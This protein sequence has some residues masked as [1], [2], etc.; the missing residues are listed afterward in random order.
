MKIRL[1]STLD[2][3][4]DPDGRPDVVREMFELWSRVAPEL[5]PSYADWSEPPR[6]PFLATDLDGEARR[7]GRSWLAKRPDRKLRVD[8]VRGARSN[9]STITFD[10]RGDSNGLDP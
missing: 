1:L 9:Y 10:Y 7:L 3:P 8:T 5:L 6:H 2:I 4:F